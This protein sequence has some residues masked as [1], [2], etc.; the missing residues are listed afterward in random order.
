MKA[1]SYE[2]S[3]TGNTT[4]LACKRT[5]QKRFENAQSL[6]AATGWLKISAENDIN[7]GFKHSG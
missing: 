7:K 5:S 1:T 6:A 2:H 4:T 3:T